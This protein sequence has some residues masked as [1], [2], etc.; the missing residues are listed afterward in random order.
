MM[1]SSFSFN[2]QIVQ[3]LHLCAGLLT[4]EG[5]DEGTLLFERVNCCCMFM[6]GL[7]YLKHCNMSPSEL[8]HQHWRLID[9][10]NSQQQQQLLDQ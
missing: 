7:V 3:V 5:K 9:L 10:D 6:L 1:M 4:K 8:Y 2:F